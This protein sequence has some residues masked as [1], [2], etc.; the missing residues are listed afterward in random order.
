MG[1]I[2]YTL[3]G[4][5]GPSTTAQFSPLGDFLLTGGQD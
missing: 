2:M 5:E 1:Q 3:F 4:H